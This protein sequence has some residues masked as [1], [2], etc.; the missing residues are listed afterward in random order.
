MEK[1][2]SFR[3]EDARG[4]FDLMIE[5]RVGKDFEAGADRAALGIVGAIDEARDAGLDD[6]AGAHAARFDGDVERGIGEA[7]IAEQARSFAEDDDF[8][9]GSGVI[10]TDSAIAGA[11]EDFAVVDNRGANGNLACGSRGQGFSERF[12]HELDI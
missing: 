9:V 5:A 6:G 3:G 1:G 7:I 11:R 4:D 12:L 8:G 10:I 2:G